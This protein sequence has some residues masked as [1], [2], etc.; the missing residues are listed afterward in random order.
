MLAGFGWPVECCGGTLPDLVL[1]GMGAAVICGTG[2][3]GMNWG[4]N[5]VAPGCAIPPAANEVATFV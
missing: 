4:I 5:G 2:K 3:F 1:Y